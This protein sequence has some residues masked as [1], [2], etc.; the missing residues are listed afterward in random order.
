[1]GREVIVSAVLFRA[2]R[3][4]VGALRSAGWRS[5]AVALLYA[6]AVGLGFAV[7]KLPALLVVAFAVENI[8]TFAVVRMLAAHRPAGV[9]ELTTGRRV[10]P[11]GTA[12]RSLGRAS[13]NAVRLTRP[14]LRLALIQMLV[15]FSALLIL[16][17]LAGADLVSS[18]NPTRQDRILVVAGS[19]PIVAL[20]SAFI[21]LAPQR[22]ALEGDERVLIAVAHSVRIAR[23]VFGVLLVLALGEPL[24]AL[25]QALAPGGV[26]VDVAAAV[27]YVVLQL[28]VVAARTEVYLEGPRLDVPDDFGI[29]QRR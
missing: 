25:A 12:D 6:P 18:E 10:P 13:A 3:D 27:A 1:M 4:A 5:L 23:T 14:A 29:R 9:P 17:A 22:I 7:E 21:A 24:L 15:V 26:V 19:G 28:V 16:V 20:L 2:V 8:A 11:V